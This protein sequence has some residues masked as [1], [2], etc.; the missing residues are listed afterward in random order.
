MFKLFD[1]VRHALGFEQFL[2]LCA[3]L[4]CQM[5]IFRSQDGSGEI[6]L[7]ELYT[8]LAS[9]PGVTLSAIQKYRLKSQFS[10]MDGNRDRSVTY[11]EFEKAA[12]AALSSGRTNQMQGRRV[13]STKGVVGLQAKEDALKKLRGTVH[14]TCA[15][16]T[17][18]CV[19]ADFQSLQKQRE[20]EAF[21]Y[22]FF[23]LLALSR[24]STLGKAHKPDVF[25][26]FERLKEMSRVG[27]ATSISFCL[28][29][30]GPECRCVQLLHC[31]AFTQS[32][33]EAT[34]KLPP[35]INLP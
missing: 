18:S 33:I 1:K 27:A 29:G 6:K 12:L 28:R 10:H 16:C 5:Q 32:A 14:L 31:Q 22:D 19:Y 7:D 2:G 11:P 17:C 25:A 30:A 15:R 13:Q 3:A 24:R 34:A 23:T 21:G 20:A 26:E 8:E 9:I 4:M 35:P